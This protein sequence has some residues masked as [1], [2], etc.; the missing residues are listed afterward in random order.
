MKG[1][2]WKKLKK[3]LSREELKLLEEGVVH[4]REVVRKKFPFVITLAGVIGLVATLYGIEKLLD[5]TFLVDH[6]WF[7]LLL[8]V[9]ILFA[10]GLLYEKL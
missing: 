9:L 7:L 4:E 2:P 10:T 5:M 8:G 6:P 1:H 3:T